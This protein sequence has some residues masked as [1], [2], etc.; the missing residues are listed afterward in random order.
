M[1][2][3]WNDPTATET[4]F[5]GGRFHTGDIGMMDEAGYVSL[6][7]RQKDMILVG[8]FNVYPRRIE[9]AIREHASV[10]DVA[11]VGID[12]EHFGQVPKAFIVQRPGTPPVTL[13]QLLD[14]L[15]DKLS[16][17]EMPLALERR[18]SLPKTSVGKIA[19]RQLAESSA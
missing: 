5:R 7:D 1:K 16:R 9:D 3:Y 19:K 17:Y 2:G 11:V 10:A 12:D 15:A 6:L 18:D 4:A 14:F 8:A 13:S